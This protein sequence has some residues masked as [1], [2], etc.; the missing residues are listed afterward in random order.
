MKVHEAARLLGVTPRTLRF[1]E[2]KG[3]VAP[4]K[5]IE[6][7]YRSYSEE[8][9]IA[10]RW[11]ISLRELGIPIARIYELI[12]LLS[13]KELFF[14]KMD[15]VR[16]QLYEEMISATEA[17][18]A[19]DDTLSAWR[20]SDRPELEQAE[21]AAHQ[22]KQN[23]SLRS[24][25]KDEWNYDGMAV[26]HGQNGPL[27][28]LSPY[29]TP[30]LYE[31]ALRRTADWIDPSADEEGLDAGA[32]SG[33]L[34]V[35]LQQSGARIT[36]VEQS[37]EMVSLLRERLPTADSRQGNLLALPVSDQSFDFI[38]CTF[39]LQHLTPSGQLLTLA[40]MDRALRPGGRL[41]L[42]G[43]MTDS[44]SLAHS[45]TFEGAAPLSSG[46]LTASLLTELIEWLQ[47]KSYSVVVETIHDPIRL[48]FAAKP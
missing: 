15:G 14:K 27:V 6:N 23:R 8:D 43:W 33:N 5:E 2:E 18:R 21:L 25:W 35:L 46:G 13:H 32:G 24:A 34:T 31:R 28:A 45:A 17:L 16:A 22:M 3:L 48:L 42:T 44:N 40:E 4:Q 10:L 36:A 7:G 26:Q 11:A 39:A 29:L 41:V 9:L 38:A 47:A 12:P 19:F 1:Y 37:G 20:G 30:Q